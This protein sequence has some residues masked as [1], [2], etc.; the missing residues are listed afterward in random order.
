MTQRLLLALAL[1]V[2][3]A[4]AAHAQGTYRIYG[5]YP[6]ASLTGTLT[7]TNFASVPIPAN[8]MGPNGLARLT[9]TTNNSNSANTKT[10]IIRMGLT[11][12]AIGNPQMNI[13]TTTTVTAQTILFFRNH[14]ATGSNGVWGNFTP[15]G[16]AAGAENPTSLDTTQ[17]IY[18]NIDGVLTNTGDTVGL[19]GWTLE[20]I[21]P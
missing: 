7:E 2:G 9:L 12:G 6:N 1:L 13:S 8:S 18:F 19:Y 20:I 3:L 21:T 17:T 15:Y 10:I 14:N 16:V 4:G 11:P 5:D